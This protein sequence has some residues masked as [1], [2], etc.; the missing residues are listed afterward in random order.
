MTSHESVGV[1]HFSAWPIIAMAFHPTE[2]LERALPAPAGGQ[3]SHYLDTPQV[4]ITSCKSIIGF[5][6]RDFTCLLSHEFIKLQFT[7][8]TSSVA[9]C[10]QDECVWTTLH[11][12][13][14]IQKDGQ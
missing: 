1:I 4:V 6:D 8:L 7:T 13:S 2:T 14:R 10:F 9:A 5:Y 11:S 3:R 12:P